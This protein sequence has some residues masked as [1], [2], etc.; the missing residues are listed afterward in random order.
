MGG[1]GFA[2]QV[3]LCKYICHTSKGLKIKTYN[4][5]TYNIYIYVQIHRYI[6]VYTH[7]YIYIY[8]SRW[9]VYVN[10]YIHQ[11]IYVDKYRNI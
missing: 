9:H 1:W 2:F 3:G 8:G 6:D 11:N 5:Y 4:I 7:T 10:V